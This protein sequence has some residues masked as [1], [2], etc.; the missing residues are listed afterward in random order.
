MD[1]FKKGFSMAKDGVVAAAEKTKA[2]V[3][4]A[5]AKTKEGVIYVG[6]MD[7]WMDGWMEQN[8]LILRIL[9]VKNQTHVTA[10]IFSPAGRDF[11]EKSDV[12]RTSSFFSTKRLQRKQ[13]V[14]YSRKVEV[15]SAGKAAAPPAGSKT[16]EGVVT[17]VN[18]VAQKTNEQANIVAD[19][20]VAG[21]NEVAQATVEGVENAALA[22]GFVNTCVTQTKHIYIPMKLLP[23]NVR[24]C[25][26][27]L[28]ESFDASN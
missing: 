11:P 28:L 6:E 12:V 15:V 22:T 4:E 18:T 20:A 3:E 1:V 26:W 24:L 17:G 2:G 16:M 5:A 27:S 23:V 10:L 9:T 21:A 13:L 8:S 19:T 14:L 7:G 25:S